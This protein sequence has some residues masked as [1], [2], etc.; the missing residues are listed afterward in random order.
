MSCSICALHMAGWMQLMCVCHSLE[1]ALRLPVCQGCK[2]WVKVPC[3]SPLLVSPDPLILPVINP[4]SS[5][6]CQYCDAGEA[7]DHGRERLGIASTISSMRP[8]LESLYREC[9]ASSELTDLDLL[10]S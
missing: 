10:S 8:G 7:L 4:A 1:S 3:S 2:G 6:L 9:R 5:D